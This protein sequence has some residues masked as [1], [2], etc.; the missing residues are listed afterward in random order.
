MYVY[1][2][3]SFSYVNICSA[4]VSAAKK[5][6]KES[7]AP[8]SLYVH[9]GNDLYARRTWENWLTL[10]VHNSNDFWFGCAVSMQEGRNMNM[11]NAITVSDEKSD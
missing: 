11:E 8:F 2:C 7:A 9:M 6:N 3:I 1:V 10:S 5:G 4:T